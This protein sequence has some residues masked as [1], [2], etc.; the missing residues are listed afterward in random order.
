MILILMG[1]N[2]QEKTEISLAF[3][4][5]NYKHL[6]SRIQRHILTLG[7][8]TT[9]SIPFCKLIKNKRKHHGT[10]DKRSLEKQFRKSDMITFVV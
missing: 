1:K 7:S 3:E 2:I 9:Q 8:M 5:A 4:K 6:I 10:V